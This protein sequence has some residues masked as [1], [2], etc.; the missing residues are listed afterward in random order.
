MYFWEHAFPVLEVIKAD[1]RA[2]I[3]KVGEKDLGRVVG[4]DAGRDYY[5]HPSCRA[6]DGPRRFREDGVGIDVPSSGESGTR[7][8]PR[9][10]RLV[11]SEPWMAWANSFG[12]SRIVLR[13]RSNQS[14]AGRLVGSGGDVAVSCVEE[15]LLL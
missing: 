9:T 15:L 11:D 10:K 3:H 4:G 12:Q 1:Q 5:S 6:A 14:L 13:Q 7:S 2:S 8:L